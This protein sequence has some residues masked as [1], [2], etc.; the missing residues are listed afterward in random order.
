VHEDTESMSSFELDGPAVKKD[1]TLDLDLN[2]RTFGVSG[3]PKLK[4]LLKGH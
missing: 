2:D 3:E 1:E 4:N